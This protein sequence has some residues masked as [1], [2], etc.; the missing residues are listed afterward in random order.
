MSLVKTSDKLQLEVKILH[1]RSRW[2]MTF[3]NDFVVLL[4]KRGLPSTGTLKLLLD[5]TLDR[6]MTSWSPGGA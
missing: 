2:N 1:G 6:K 3:M 4:E 5:A